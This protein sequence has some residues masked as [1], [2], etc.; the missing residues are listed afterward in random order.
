MTFAGIIWGPATKYER[1]INEIF[2]K[3]SQPLISLKLDLDDMYDDFV[4][5]IYNEEDTPKWKIHEKVR[6]MRACD[7]KSVRVVFFDI[8]TSKTHYHER[9]KYMVYSNVENMKGEVRDTV[10]DRIDD[11]FFDIVFHLTDNDKELDYTARVVKDYIRK[12]SERDD[13]D[14]KYI[15]EA[16]TYYQNR[17][18]PRLCASYLGLDTSSTAGGVVSLCDAMQ[19]DTSDA[20][21][22]TIIDMSEADSPT[23]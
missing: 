2:P 22:A 15:E 17:D 23:M 20:S 5:D 9:K 12:V 8:D 11:Y 16:V 4:Y 13:Y 1:E 14:S 6:H 19:A 21:D 7:D 18:I 3:Y 10:R